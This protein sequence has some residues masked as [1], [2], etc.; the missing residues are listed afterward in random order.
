MGCSS[1]E[2]EDTVRPDAGEVTHLDMGNNLGCHQG[3]SA[4]PQIQGP[5]Y[6]RHLEDTWGYKQQAVCLAGGNL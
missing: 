5:R 3:Q 4:K 6:L 2:E 1:R